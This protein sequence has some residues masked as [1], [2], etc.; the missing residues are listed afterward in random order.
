MPLT[1]TQKVTIKVDRKYAGHFNQSS[2]DFFTSINS[3]HKIEIVN[4]I[5]IS[6]W[7]QK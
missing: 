1:T 7:L 6:F 5:D 4:E 3:Y 2:N